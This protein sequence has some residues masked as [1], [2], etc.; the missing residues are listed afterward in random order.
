M[1]L[2]FYV[3]RIFVYQIKQNPAAEILENVFR[4]FRVTGDEIIFE[5]FEKTRVNRQNVYQRRIS[6]EIDGLDSA[7]ERRIG[8]GEF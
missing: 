4:L 5:I 6:D 8:F 7:F 3:E 1:F 2:K